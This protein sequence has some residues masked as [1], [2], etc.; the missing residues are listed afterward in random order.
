MQSL[1]I[2]EE[3]EQQGIHLEKGDFKHCFENFYSG[4]DTIYGS[5]KTEE[6]R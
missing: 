1:L 5:V 6:T 2:K 3:A 4:F